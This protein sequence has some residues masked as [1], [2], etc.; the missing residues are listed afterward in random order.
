MA[1]KGALSKKER[2]RI[3]AEGN[4]ETFIR[5]VAPHNVMGGVHQEVCSWWTRQEAKDHQLLLL[6]RDHGKS[7]YAAYRAAWAVTNKPDIRILYLSATSGLAEKQLKFIKDIFESDIY[8]YYWPE[9]VN[10]E[11][12]KR[13]KW[14]NSEISVDHPK[15]KAEGVRDSTI[16]TGGLTT[17][18]TG[19][20]CDI[21]ILDDIVVAE[22]AQTDEGRDKVKR[23]YS[24]L[25]SIEGGMAEEWVVGTRYHPLDLYGEMLQMKA[26]TFDKEGEMT[27]T[28]DIYE[29]FQRQVESVG[30]G[31]GEFLW[32]RQ[33][34]GDGV[35]FG[36]NR[37]ILATKRGKYLDKTQYRAQYYN[38]PN[39]TSEAP[40]DRSTFQYYDPAFLKWANN[41]WTFKGDALNIV[42]SVDF[43][44]SLGNR[45]DYTAIVVLGID[46]ERNKYILGIDRFKTTRISEY[47][48]RILELH[49]K[50][51]FRKLIAET[52]AAQKAIVEE[53]KHSYIRPHGLALSIK[54]QKPTRHQGSK[55][56]RLQAIL[57]PAY[58]NEAVWHYRGGHCQTLEEELVLQFPPHDD[59]KDALASAIEHATPPTAN[60]AHRSNVYRLQGHKR[61]G[62]IAG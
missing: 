48:T 22:N 58:E 21:A 8:R 6:P 29:V 39:D 24:L 35:W 36:F 13:E 55:E 45:S 41:G 33:Q 62:G 49:E 37:A 40:I 60:S 1:S 57:E 59:I 38:N 7:R 47:F 16:F 30:D 52:T 26:E 61:F 20:H 5:L 17:S 14:T 18:L 54:E 2:I 31:S 28:R 3:A 32:P 23:Q 53:L 56:E 19:L 34:R 50:W 51:G 12:S 27:G 11:I 4:L 42:A 15:R 46:S 25:A 44:Y 9:M 10:K 43:A